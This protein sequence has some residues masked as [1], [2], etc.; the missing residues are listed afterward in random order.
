MRIILI[1]VFCSLTA[2]LNAQTNTYLADLAAL[3]SILQKTPSYKA[4]IKGDKQSRYNSLYDRLIL[5]T[6]NNPSTFQYFFNLSQLLFPLRDNHLGFYQLPNYANFKTKESIDSFTKTKEFLDYPAIKINIDSLKEVLAIKP[7]SSMEGIY[8]YGK[9][10][11]VGLFKSSDKEYIGVIVN[12]EVNLWQKGMVAIH[13]Y[14][15]SPNLFK[16][17]YG[18]PLFKNFI[19]QTNEKYRNQSLVNSYF[20]G[21]YSQDIYSKQLQQNDYIN[22]PKNI[23]KFELRNINDNVQYLLIRSFQRNKTTMQESKKF[24]D[25]IKN[26]LTASNLL[27]DLRNNE[28]GARKE[29]KKYFTLLK[30]YTK[31]GHLYILLNNETLSQ[32]EIFTLRLKKLKNVTTIGQSTKGMLTYGSNYGRRQ[33]LPS[34]KFEIYPTDMKGNKKL[35]QYENYGIIPDISL[36]QNSDWI[37]QVIKIIQEK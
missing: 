6:T 17:I 24:Y 20:Y 14:E 32:A 19:L 3:K 16:A 1:S 26:T 11:S 35:L 12:S 27:L 31:K 37:G 10:Y 22:I 28:G 13:L 4:Q 9:F 5:D 7:D 33:K 23:S 30:K 29:T 18:H 8:H 21:S 2:V 34:G 15:Y 25:S 36:N